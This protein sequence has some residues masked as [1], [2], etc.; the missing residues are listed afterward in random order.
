MQMKRELKQIYD[1]LSNGKLSQKEALGKI[2]AIKQKG[3]G[4]GRG[5]MLMAPG[6]EARGVEGW[7]GGSGIEYAGH[8]V[9]LCEVGEVRAERL[10]TLVGGSQ[11]VSLPAGGEKDKEK[12]IAE[13]YGEYAL[14]IFER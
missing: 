7:G 14:A 10:G 3:Q 13:R 11:C 5:E 6:W 2:K 9:I 1:D 4:K 12:D 8:E